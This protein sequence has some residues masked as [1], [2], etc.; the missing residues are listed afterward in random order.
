VFIETV[1][2]IPGMGRL[3]TTAIFDYDYQIVQAAALIFGGIVIFSNLIVDIS[4]GW[5]DPRIRYG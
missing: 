2:S 1:F 5:L 3:M 4:W